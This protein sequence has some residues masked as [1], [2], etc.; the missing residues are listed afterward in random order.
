MIVEAS[1]VEDIMAGLD[2]RMQ[3]DQ[4]LNV[5]GAEEFAKFAAG[6]VADALKRVSGVNVV[7][8]QFAIIRGLEDRYSSTTFNGAP[9]PSPDPDRQS[10][11]LDLFAS[12]IVSS[13]QIAKTFG[14][15]QPSNSA[16]G[17]IDI[18]TMDYP[19]EFQFKLNLGTGFNGGAIDRFQDFVEDSPVGRDRAAS[20]TIERDIGGSVG[21][22]FGAWKREFRYRALLNHEI[23]YDTRDGFQERREP[24]QGAINQ[25]SGIAVQNGDLAFG[26][27]S[28]S[29]GRF[30]LFESRFS[31]VWTAFGAFGLDLDEAAAHRVDFTAFYSKKTEETISLRENGFIPGVDYAALRQRH[32]DKIAEDGPVVQPIGPNDFE[33]CG[34]Q[35]PVGDAI[36]IRESLFET[37]AR[38]ALW[39][40]NYT[41]A[42]SF[43][44]ERDLLLLQLN[45][46][47]RLGFVPG[48][49]VTWVGNYA[50]TTDSRSALRAKTFFEPDEKIT[51]PLELPA[52][53]AA[54]GPGNFAV[55]GSALSF[56]TIQV[57]EDQ[58]FARLDAKYERSLLEWARI[59]LDTGG[60][61]ERAGRDVSSDFLESPL[62]GGSSQFAIQAPTLSELGS[63][64]LDSLSRDA[65]GRLNGLRATTSSATRRYSPGRCKARQRCST[66]SI[67]SRGCASSSFASRRRTMPS[68][69]K[70]PSTAHP[71][72]FRRNISSSIGPTIRRATT[73][74]GSLV[75]DP[76]GTTRSSQLR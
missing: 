11:Q 52:S 46:D 53:V 12:D 8:G 45:G 9:V 41:T 33:C 17:S 54:L 71:R 5:M 43:D 55:P 59:Q 28:L 48:L 60:W 73:A 3:S 13:V 76:S 22:R 51:P 4:L 24:I 6:D 31:D 62:I 19:G 67:Y 49:G 42:S 70:S 15:N 7:G 39:F 10:V 34:L 37:P 57:E 47:H 25:R 1:A 40:T 21:G 36:R 29:N 2:L 18:V 65:S 50:K 69:A 58:W 72:S 66:T 68:R 56:S 32:I 20:D 44:S 26:R 27:L 74:L 61:Y 63:T 75:G 14:A 16:G 30:D 64:I 23:D 35:D 38:G